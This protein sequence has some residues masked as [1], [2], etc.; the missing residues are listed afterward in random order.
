MGVGAWVPVSLS[1]AV[2]SA[3]FDCGVLVAVSVGTPRNE[4]MVAEATAAGV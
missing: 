2:D 4:A 1:K 3:E